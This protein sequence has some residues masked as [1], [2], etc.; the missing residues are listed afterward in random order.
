M[1][2]QNYHLLLKYLKRKYVAG[3][4]VHVSFASNLVLFTFNLVVGS[5]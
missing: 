1:M 2:R 4:A 5:N 3:M